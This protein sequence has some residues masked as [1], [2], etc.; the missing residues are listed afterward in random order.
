MSE[1]V[2]ERVLVRAASGLLWVIAASVWTACR[3]S[4]AQELHAARFRY[5]GKLTMHAEQPDAITDCSPRAGDY[6]ASG[7]MS[8]D[9]AHKSVLLDGY[10]CTL[11]VEPSG[12]GFAGAAQPC[13]IARLANFKGVGLTEL[14]FES[15]FMDASARSI[16][17][18]ARAFRE[19]PDGRVWYCMELNAELEA[20]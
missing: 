13:K 19:P 16:T 18:S 12:N 5:S 14:R 20:R 3:S 1:S 15:F 8:L 11:E 2:L 10:G 6:D 9:A 7:F 17:W 4:Q